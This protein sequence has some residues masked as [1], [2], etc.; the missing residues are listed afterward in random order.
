M[1]AK[2][3]FTSG[4]VGF[5]SNNSCAISDQA[6]YRDISADSWAGLANTIFIKAN[7][8]SKPSSISIRLW[9][10]PYFGANFWSL[11][12]LV[13]AFLCP[14]KPR[15]KLWLRLSVWSSCRKSY[16]SGAL[17]SCILHL[18]IHHMHFVLHLVFVGHV[19]QNLTW[20]L[21]LGHLVSESKK[22]L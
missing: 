10:P 6:V 3:S 8:S 15:F 5:C 21:R 12:V 1:P 19:K 11:S 13:P 22:D 2:S 14:S 4:T 18:A 20:S 7:S 9:R 16:I 17:R